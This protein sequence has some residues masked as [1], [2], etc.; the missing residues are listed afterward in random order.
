[1]TMIVDNLCL[2]AGGK[3]LIDHLDMTVEPG[4]CWF[5][6]GRNGVGKTTLLKAMAGLKKPSSGRIFL[7]DLALPEWQHRALA[8]RRAYLPQVQGDTFGF[9]VMETVLA[10]R[11]PYQTG[12]RWESGSDI[13]KAV[14]ALERVEVLHLADRDIR[15]LSGGER[16]RVAVAA[17][18]AQDAP[19]M[20]LDEPASA[21]DLSHQASLLGLIRKL[22]REQGKSVVM[23]VHDLNMAWDV[24][25]HVLLLH[26][27]GLWEA[28]KREAMMCT[29]KL[30]TC[31]Q[32]PVQ[33]VL[34]G[35]RAVFVS[36]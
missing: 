18:L 10:A 30:S 5:V 35:D 12:Y 6:Y 4:Q 7:D 32:F 20:L 11:F 29:G 1:M 25:S 36:Y 19:L 3:C 28:G 13:E 22:C 24:A 9:T 14:S 23:I 16:Q 34:H 27:D 17:L 26:G 2:Q 15:T 8:Q 21:L 31:L 33:T